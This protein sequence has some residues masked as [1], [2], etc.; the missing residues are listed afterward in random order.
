MRTHRLMT[1]NSSINHVCK[2][3]SCSSTSLLKADQ[4]KSLQDTR[5]N[6]RRKLTSPKIN[7]MNHIVDKCIVHQKFHKT[8]NTYITYTCTLLTEDLTRAN[9]PWEPHWA[10]HHRSGRQPPSTRFGEL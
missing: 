9:S 3:W 8:S 10:H 7:A 6:K 4:A 1:I 5:L 2:S